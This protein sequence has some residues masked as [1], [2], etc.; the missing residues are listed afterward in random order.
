M[1]HACV[2]LLLLNFAP[3]AVAQ[4]RRRTP[5]PRP[6]PQTPARPR[7]TPDASTA[8]TQAQPRRAEPDISFEEM[9]AA[10]S[11]TVYLELRR[12]GTLARAEEVKSAVAS[13]VLFGASEAKPLTDLYAFVSDNAEALGESRVVAAFLP[14]RSEVPQALLA[15][16]LESPAAAAAFEPKLRRMLGEGVPQVKKALT[17]T[18]PE[19]VVV[20]QPDAAAERAR[21]AA[22]SAAKAPAADF[23]LKRT[24]RWL[25]AADAPFTL[26]RLRGEEGTQSL[27]DS[28]R[29]QSVRARFASDALFVYV[30]T[31]VAQQGWALQ[32]QR[33]AEAQPPPPTGVVI[34]IGEGRPGEPT[35]AVINPTVVINPEEAQPETEGGSDEMVPD[36]ELTPEEVAVIAAE[37]GEGEDLKPEPPPPPTEEELALMGMSRVLGSLWGGAPRIPGAFALG[38]SLDRGALAVR[39]AVE[40]T[41]DGLVSIIPF[42]PNLVSGPPVTTETAA[43]A[44][45]DAELYIAGSLDWTQVYNQTLGAAALSPV[46]VSHTFPEGDGEGSEKARQ[47]PTVDETIAAVEKLFGFKFKE[48]LLPALGNEV[49]VSVPLKETMLG[50]PRFVSEKKKKEEKEKRDAEPGFLY[51]AALNNPERVREILPRALVAFGFAAPSTPQRAEKRKGFD[52]HTLGAGGG[53]SYAIINNFLVAGELKAVRHCVDSFDARQTLASVN[54]YR[55]AVAWQAKQK[56]IHVYISDTI[57][58]ATLEE[59]QR[60]SGGSTDPVLRALLAQLEAAETAPASY[61]AT[62]EGDVVIHEVRVPIS[63]VRSYALAIAVSVKDA[64]VLMNESMAFYALQRIVWAESAYKD[65]KKKERFGTLEELLAEQLLEKTFFENME[66]KFEVE[67]KGDKFE[68]SATP[69]SYGKTGRRS[70]FLDQAGIFHAADHKG[71]PATSDDPAVDQ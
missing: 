49:A 22:K 40:N 4:R 26:K 16:E 35:T 27:A 64:P 55:D 10:D 52:I 50:G 37:E 70:F 63:L 62:N 28:A 61:E 46:M 11:Y 39:L 15:I 20:T 56:L 45:A 68:V 66:Y 23:A 2:T 44:P 17:S 58:K 42:L 33:A 59:T 5:A 6:Q 1:T 7:A 69:K 65:E 54:T 9:L 30:D 38:A 47:Q 36:S 60:R 51:L 32:M 48:D 21:P 3:A 24:G 53:F 29:F 34:G 67:V 41:P 71:Q 18:A 13:L 19:P 8:R 25:L 31:N 43:V 12:V 57:M 14:A